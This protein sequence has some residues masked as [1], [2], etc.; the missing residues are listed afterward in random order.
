MIGEFLFMGGVEQTFD[1]MIICFSSTGPELF[2]VF[3]ELLHI[4]VLL[5]LVFLT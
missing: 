2:E 5:Y 3:G 4:H 1:L